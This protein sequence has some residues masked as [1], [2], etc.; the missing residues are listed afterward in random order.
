M[1]AIAQ[2]PYGPADVLEL[3]DVDRPGGD[4]RYSS[5]ACGRGRPAACGTFM[6]GRPYLV[7]PRVGLRRPKL[8][9]RGRDLAG[10]VAAVGAGVTRL[11]PGDEVYGTCATGSFA[12]YAT[13]RRSGSRSN[14]PA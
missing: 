6:T 5:G 7:R 14:R 1:K 4:A 8:P 11:R 12:E 3:R 9:V 13:A 10:V 2:D